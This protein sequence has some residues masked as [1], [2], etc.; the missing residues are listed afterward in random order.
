MTVLGPGAA[1]ITH[2]TTVDG[3]CSGQP[4]PPNS[5]VASVYVREGNQWKAAF[6]AE[7]AIVDPAAPMAKPVAACV[8]P[9]SIN[10]WRLSSA[11]D[12]PDFG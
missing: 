2:K 9:Y 3:T 4:S 6:H 8:A 11:N 7:A 1:L 10:D 5:W 12:F